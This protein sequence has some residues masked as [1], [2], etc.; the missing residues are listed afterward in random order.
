MGYPVLLFFIGIQH[1]Q[2]FHKNTKKS[3]AKNE[4][5]NSISVFLIL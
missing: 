5:L 2:V 1:L 3:R 4:Q